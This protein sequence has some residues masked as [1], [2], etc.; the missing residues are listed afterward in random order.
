MLV[1]LGPIGLR[2]DQDSAVIRNPSHYQRFSSTTYQG[3]IVV[4]RHIALPEIHLG[5]YYIFTGTL[6]DLQQPF[7]PPTTIIV[8]ICFPFFLRHP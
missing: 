6:V 1:L 8:A 5:R 4:I 3:H 7:P 2:I